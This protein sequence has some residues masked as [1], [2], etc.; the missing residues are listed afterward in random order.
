MFCYTHDDIMG[1]GDA[2]FQLDR[3]VVIVMLSKAKQIVINIFFRYV[4]K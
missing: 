1:E 4:H 3:F 2:L